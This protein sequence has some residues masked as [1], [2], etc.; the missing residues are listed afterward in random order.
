M[1][2]Y[3]IESTSTGK[4]LEV[5]KHGKTVFETFRELDPSL[6]RLH[7]IHRHPRE[8]ELH[9]FQEVMRCKDVSMIEYGDLQTLLGYCG[10]YRNG[11][12]Q[13]FSSPMLTY[14]LTI[15]PTISKLSDLDD[16]ILSAHLITRD[17]LSSIAIDEFSIVPLEPNVVTRVSISF[18]EYIRFD[19][20]FCSL[21]SYPFFLA[22]SS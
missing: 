21:R 20:L 9:V 12:F 13:G 17:V 6:E 5:L 4:I 22:L 18:S 3:K 11:M 16:P 8:N 2:N 19:R 1:V 14:D 7:P 15:S 10:V